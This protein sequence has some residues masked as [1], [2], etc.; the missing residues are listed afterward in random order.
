MA[1]GQSGSSKRARTGKEPDTLPTTKRSSAYDLNF[2]QHLIDHGVYPDGYDDASNVQE[3][4][5][6]EEIRARLAVRRALLSPSH[7]T[8]EAFLDFKTK[9]NR[10]LTENSVMSKAF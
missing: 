8:R 1:S 3:P 10:A 2:E 9:N 6:L 4:H 5:N 7:F